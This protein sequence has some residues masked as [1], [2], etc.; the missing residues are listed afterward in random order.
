MSQFS[1]DVPYIESKSEITERSRS[2]TA[3]ENTYKGLT[4]LY[5]HT[6]W[7][8]IFFHYYIIAERSKSATLSKKYV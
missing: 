2:A 6:I 8:F 7:C 5:H 4:I 3:S 1:H